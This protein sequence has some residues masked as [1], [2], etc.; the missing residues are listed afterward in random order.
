MV[1][2]EFLATIAGQK[3]LRHLKYRLTLVKHRL[4]SNHSR[5]FSKF[6]SV[7]LLQTVY[8]NQLLEIIP[9]I[10]VFQIIFCQYDKVIG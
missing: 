4:H 8:F 3:S 7:K 10:S 5:F 2:S 6:L 1:F 9:S